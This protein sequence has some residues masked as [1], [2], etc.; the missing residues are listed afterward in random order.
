[1]L[2]IPRTEKTLNLL[3]IFAFYIISQVSIFSLLS[4]FSEYF[5][6]KSDI[7]EVLD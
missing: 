6:I 5:L 1:M 2:M 4:W 3:L 7:T